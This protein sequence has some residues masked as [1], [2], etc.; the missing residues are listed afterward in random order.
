MSNNFRQKKLKKEWI[1]INT[2]FFTGKLVNINDD[3]NKNGV[4]GF[5]DCFRSEE[6][7]SY[8]RYCFNAYGHVISKF[9]CLEKGDFVSG[10]GNF[11]VDPRFRINNEAKLQIFI[12][13]IVKI[14][15]EKTNLKSDIIDELEL[16]KINISDEGDFL[17]KQYKK[18]YN[19]ALELKTKI[20]LSS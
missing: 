8:T 12:E 2:L 20:N 4:Y 17:K 18:I 3:K 13:D 14:E 9:K 16:L 6:S 1:I 19:F 11:I 10:K 7:K 5:I 15:E